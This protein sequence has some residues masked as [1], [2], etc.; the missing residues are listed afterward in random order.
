MLNTNSF[1][2]RIKQ[3]RD[4]YKSVNSTKIVDSNEIVESN[5]N[6][7]ENETKKVSNKRKRGYNG[8]NFD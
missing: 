7:N 4:F 8:V 5:E 3:T 2:S 1:K 6:N